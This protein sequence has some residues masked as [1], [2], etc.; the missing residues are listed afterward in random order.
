MQLA[1]EALRGI[2]IRPAGDL[3]N[4]EAPA[5]DG[6]QLVR[7]E[8]HGQGLGVLPQT[9]PVGPHDPV[10]VFPLGSVLGRLLNAASVL[11]ETGARPAAEELADACRTLAALTSIPSQRLQRAHKVAADAAARARLDQQVAERGNGYL[12]MPAAEATAALETGGR[13]LRTRDGVFPLPQPGQAQDAWVVMR[14]SG[15]TAVGLLLTGIEEFRSGR[16]A[17]SSES[18]R[19]A[20]SSAAAALQPGP[21]HLEWPRSNDR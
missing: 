9:D 13:Q 2:V 12:P 1:E 10:L 18:L 21:A 15:I 5:L 3:A 7:E 14:H 17:V 4:P 6:W 8:L 11:L 20:L 16:D 19:R